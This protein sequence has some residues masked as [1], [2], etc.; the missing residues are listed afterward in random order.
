MK[1]V[2]LITIL[3]HCL[4]SNTQLSPIVRT[5]LVTK[6]NQLTF[7][8]LEERQ[9]IWHTSNLKNHNSYGI[10]QTRRTTALLSYLKMKSDSS[11]LIPQTQERHFSSHISNSKTT[12]HLA[13]HE[14]EERQLSSHASNSSRKSSHITYVQLKYFIDYLTGN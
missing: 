6:L 8:K 9:L 7:L 11:P 14:L 5:K 4:M 3:F 1:P 10:L 2:V 12:T 13:Y